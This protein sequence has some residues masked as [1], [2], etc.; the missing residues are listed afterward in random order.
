M[1]FNVKTQPLA[2]FGGIFLLF[3]EISTRET[4]RVKVGVN[5][6]SRLIWMFCL[7]NSLIASGDWNG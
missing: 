4:V 5:V 3:W 2:L 1:L 7:L 6:F